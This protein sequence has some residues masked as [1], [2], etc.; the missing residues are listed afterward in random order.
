MNGRQSFLKGTAILISANAISK[1]LGAIFKIPLTYILQE[2]GM[3]IFNTALGV[4]STLLTFVISGLPLALSRFM[5]E[6][7]ALKNYTTVKK[8]VRTGTLILCAL[9]ISGSLCLFF[10]QFA[11]R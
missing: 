9:G 4:Y 10:Y 11:S 8:C 1:I 2:E 6:E 3:A 5:A 7:Y